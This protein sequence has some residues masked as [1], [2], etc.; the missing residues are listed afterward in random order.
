MPAPWTS[1]AALIALSLGLVFAPPRQKSK[2]KTSTSPRA[3]TKTKTKAKA[4]PSKSKSKQSKPKRAPL[5]AGKP[6]A[7]SKTFRPKPGTKPARKLSRPKGKPARASSKKAKALATAYSTREK[8]APR[9]AKKDLK[10][11]RKDI[12][13][14]QYSFEV[15]YTDAMARPVG[16][17][18]GLSVPAKPLRDAAKQNSR[19][20]QATQGRDLMVRSLSRTLTKPKRMAEKDKGGLPG[21]LGAPVGSSSNSDTPASVGSNF[22]DICSPSAEAFTWQSELGA[23]RNQGACGSCWAFAAVSTIEASNAIV[24]GG[25][26]D[27]SEQHALSCSDG[28]TCYGGWYT[29]IYDWLSGGKDGLETEAAVPYKG[30]ASSCQNGGSTPYEVEAWGWVDPYKVQPGVEDIKASICK[31]GALTS[32]VAATPA[33][34]AYSGGTFDERSSAQVNHA[35]TLVGWDDSRNA[36]LMRNSW[37][38]NWGESGYMWIDYGSNSIG[39]YST[40]ALV[41]ADAKANSNTDEGP[42]VLS[43]SERNLRV[44]NET[45]KK[46]ELAV[47]WYTKRD[48]KWQWLPGAPGSSKSAGYSLAN[49]QSLNLDDPTHEPF[50]LQAKKVR[51]WASASGQ[52]WEH[53]KT[54]DLDLAPAAYEATEMDVF[55]LRLLPGGKDSAGGGEPDQDPSDL[56]DAAYDL[57]GAGKYAEAK[58]EF[59]AWKAQNPT[60]PDVPYA[61]YFMGV[62]EH[63]LDNYWDSLLYFA[64]FA[65][66]HSDHDWLPYVYYWA[67]SSYVGLG[68]CGYAVQL[69]EA[70]AYSDLGSSQ[71]WIKAAK[72]TIDWLGKD[73]GKVCKSWD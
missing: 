18:A 36:W 67:G 61:L 21:G 33:F 45:G 65:D 14:K 39:A 62:A 52:S 24:N 15:S 51:L 3:T 16:E 31:Y 9:R 32:A 37:G 59:A 6:P 41:E 72:D 71:E 8:K 66:H 69:Y 43:H 50:M 57:F 42:K 28:G 4:P 73:D 70:V 2:T 53:W 47:Q 38:S 44:T 68:D 54:R 1:H 26:S 30:S 64:E 22:A 48:G 34:I 40:W 11:L 7:V 56:F 27:L 55:E 46:V 13:K 23:I 58:A 29:P 5:K 63:Q 25:R 10:Q 49:G 35:V 17:L 12:A 19:A 20:R 60:S